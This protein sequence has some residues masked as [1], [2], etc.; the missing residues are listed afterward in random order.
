MFSLMR[1][2]PSKLISTLQIGACLAALA[3]TSCTRGAWQ[4]MAA[5]PSAIVSY[6]DLGTAEMLTPVLGP[7]GD[8]P[9]IKVHLGGTSATSQPRRLSAYNGLLML[10]HNERALPDTPENAALRERMRRAYSHIYQFYR[11]RRDAAMSTPPFVGRGAM[12]RVQMLPSVPSS[13]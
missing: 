8:D 1:T 5:G 4:K 9:H 3:I 13:L 10:R 2:L 6:D 7:R 12:Q 11:T